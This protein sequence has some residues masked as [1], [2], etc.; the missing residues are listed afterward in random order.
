MS[1]IPENEPTTSAVLP[2]P[3]GPPGVSGF[4]GTPPVQKP[5]TSEATRAVGAVPTENT[6][7]P[8]DESNIG[9]VSVSHISV[10]ESVLEVHDPALDVS[11]GPNISHDA[12]LLLDERLEPYLRSPAGPSG[13]EQPLATGGQ[14][15][16]K[17][18]PSGAFD[19]P[20]EH[21]LEGV[22]ERN[23]KDPFL[24]SGC[25][26]TMDPW[27]F[28]RPETIESGI[29]DG[30]D[31][32]LMKS[33]FVAGMTRARQ[34]AQAIP[35]R[36]GVELTPN[37]LTN[38]M[39]V[40][41]LQADF[42]RDH[43][44]E[45]DVHP[46]GVSVSSQGNHPDPILESM[47]NVTTATAASIQTNYG[48]RDRAHRPTQDLP[49]CIGRTLLLNSNPR[50][51]VEECFPAN[52]NIT[53]MDKRL[54][55]VVAQKMAYRN[56]VA[57]RGG[58]KT[59][60]LADF[61]FMKVYRE[62][63][64][65]G[66][67][68][69]DECYRADS[70]EAELVVRDLIRIG[71]I[72]GGGEMCI[73]GLDSEH[74][75]PILGES[76]ERIYQMAGEIDKLNR[77]KADRPKWSVA[78]QDRW[79]H[80]CLSAGHLANYKKGKLLGGGNPSHTRR[81]GKIYLDTMM[82]NVLA[83]RDQLK[84]C[85]LPLDTKVSQNFVCLIQMFVPGAAAVCLQ[86]NHLEKL[87]PYLLNVLTNP[88]IKK[89]TIDRGSDSKAM[90]HSFN[91]PWNHLNG[92]IDV[93]AA[94]HDIALKP[95]GRLGANDFQRLV[96]RFDYKRPT[97]TGPRDR[98][99]K[100]QNVDY[101]IGPDQKLDADARAYV[102][103]DGALPFRAA[104]FGACVTPDTILN[105]HPGRPKDVALLELPVFN[106]LRK[107]HYLTH[108]EFGRLY[109]KYPA[110]QPENYEL[111]KGLPVI[112][113]LQD[114]VETLI[115]ATPNKADQLEY[116]ELYNHFVR[117]PR[118]VQSNYDSMGLGLVG[119]N[120][121]HECFEHRR[122]STTKTPGVTFGQLFRDKTDPYSNNHV[123]LY[124]REL[125]LYTDFIHNG[126]KE[127]AEYLISCGF[128]ILQAL[129]TH[130]AEKQSR[131]SRNEL[132]VMDYMFFRA[133][134]G[135]ILIRG[136]LWI[137]MEVPENI[138]GGTMRMA[139]RAKL[140][141][142]PE[143]RAHM[144]HRVRR[145]QIERPEVFQVNN[146]WPVDPNQKGRKRVRIGTRMWSE[147][148]EYIDTDF[149][150]YEV[151]VRRLKNPMLEISLQKVRD[152]YER[153]I[154]VRE[155]LLNTIETPEVVVT[156][157]PLPPLPEAPQAMYDFIEAEK[158][159]NRPL[160][161]GQFEAATLQNLQVIRP[162]SAEPEMEMEE[163]IRYMEQT[164]D[165]VM[166]DTNYDDTN[167]PYSCLAEPDAE[168]EAPD[169]LLQ[170]KLIDDH[171]HHPVRYG[172]QLKLYASHAS[173]AG[174]DALQQYFPAAEQFLSVN[175]PLP[176]IREGLIYLNEINVFHLGPRKELSSGEALLRWDPF[177]DERFRVQRE[178]WQI[179]KGTIGL[180]WI[181]FVH[182]LRFRATDKFSS[183]LRPGLKESAAL[184]QSSDAA[185]LNQPID[186]S[187]DELAAFD[188]AFEDADTSIYQVDTGS[189]ETS[190]MDTDVLDP[191]LY[192]QNK[193]MTMA[194]NAA[195]TQF[196]DASIM[197]TT[198]AEVIFARI[199][200]LQV[201][202]DRSEPC[203]LQD[204]EIVDKIDPVANHEYPILDRVIAGFP[205]VSFVGRPQ[206][207]LPVVTYFIQKLGR[208]NMSHYSLAV[209]LPT[210]LQH[211]RQ[212][213][214]HIMGLPEFF[215]HFDSVYARSQKV[216]QH[217]LTSQGKGS[218]IYRAIE[219]RLDQMKEVYGEVT[220][221]IY[222]SLHEQ[223]QRRCVPVDPVIQ[224]E[225]G[226]KD[227]TEILHPQLQRALDRR[228]D[229]EVELRLPPIVRIETEAYLRI[230]HPE[231][232]IFS[233]LQA[234]SAYPM[235]YV[236]S[237][238]N[239]FREN[240][241]WEFNQFYPV[242][243]GTAI[244]PLFSFT[245]LGFPEEKLSVP[246]G[247]A[248][249]RIMVALADIEATAPNVN[250]NQL[251]DFFIR[252]QHR[253]ILEYWR[254]VCGDE[255]KVRIVFRTY[256]HFL[257]ARRRL[258]AP[259]AYNKG[260]TEEGACPFV[261]PTAIDERDRFIASFC[262]ASDH[263][264]V[265]E[266]PLD[267]DRSINRNDGN[268]TIY[269]AMRKSLNGKVSDKMI[270]SSDN[271]NALRTNQA[272]FGKATLVYAYWVQAKLEYQKLTGLNDFETL[273]FI[274][275]LWRPTG[276]LAPS[277]PELLKFIEDLREYT[278]ESVD[279]EMAEQEAPGG[280]ILPAEPR[281]ELESEVSAAELSGQTISS[282][283]SP[284][285]SQRLWKKTTG[286][287]RQFGL[288]ISGK[289]K[290]DQSL[291]PELKPTE[292]R[293]RTRTSPVSPSRDAELCT[294]KATSKNEKRSK[295]PKS[296]RRRGKSA[297]RIPPPPLIP[298]SV[299]EST[300]Q[301]SQQFE[302]KAPFPPG[303]KRRPVVTE[304]AQGL[305]PP[306]SPRRRREALLPSPAPSQTTDEDEDITDHFPDIVDYEPP[307]RHRYERSPLQLDLEFDPLAA[308]DRSGGHPGAWRQRPHA[309]EYPGQ[310][311]LIRSKRTSRIDGS[312]QI[313]SGR[314][315]S[316][317]DSPQ[318][319][320]Q[321]QYQKEPYRPSMQQ[322]KEP[323]RPSMQQPKEP[324]RPKAHYSATTSPALDYDSTSLQY[325]P[326]YHGPSEGRGGNRRGPVP[327]RVPTRSQR[328]PIPA[329]R[330]NSGNR[331][332]TRMFTPSTNRAQT[333]LA[334]PGR[335][336]GWTD[337][338]RDEEHLYVPSGEQ[339]RDSRPAEYGGRGNR[340]PTGNRG[341]GKTS[342]RESIRQQQEDRERHQN[343]ILYGCFQFGKR[344]AYFPDA[345]TND[346]YMAMNPPSRF[347][348]GRRSE[349]AIKNS[350]RKSY[351][352][353]LNATPLSTT[354]YPIHPFRQYQNRSNTEQMGLDHC[355]SFILAEVQRDNPQRIFATTPPDLVMFPGN[356]SPVG[357]QLSQ[358]QA[359]SLG[360]TTAIRP[361]SPGDE[362]RKEAGMSEHYYENLPFEQSMEDITDFESMED[363]LLYDDTGEA[364]IPGSE[365]NSDHHADG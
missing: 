298:P 249:E 291:T 139:R 136:N 191:P 316:Y 299:S 93:Q 159:D 241:P 339:E 44:E 1:P 104:E 248:Q 202:T 244:P 277:I 47:T 271:Y 21:N 76:P 220:R 270:R 178:A 272:H 357:E 156:S 206:K 25:E 173:S 177:E 27:E 351:A 160:A 364:T 326:P 358:L 172:R 254:Y 212:V 16:S 49:G 80:N 90:A 146:V 74:A 125:H 333:A 110:E 297:V 256:L 127:G 145:L 301:E 10:D 12:S 35:R 118:H 165:K 186:S 223:A 126:G 305:N 122:A 40:H 56:I 310:S 314:E 236:D 203:V 37:L 237:F 124:D 176:V 33:F 267:V 30:I 75:Q 273:G 318:E 227:R 128:S 20:V 222:L 353:H 32:S 179:H 324:L 280:H 239:V 155:D 238:I 101:C 336:Q 88:L 356:H 91:I 281:V 3:L 66:N 263:D 26:S 174:T 123:Q 335:P 250:E 268:L 46:R 264:Y 117:V 342:R 113:N 14:T 65:P 152:V 234:M 218:P 92:V 226:Y 86:V 251:A 82:R 303:A 199:A 319:W 42:Y 232:R 39:G 67:L 341:R 175:R 228:A 158:R 83:S 329:P 340:R 315:R 205:L 184:I 24:E 231:R 163:E 94:M 221:I 108:Q 262:N 193:W 345:P 131:V 138:K 352:D 289:T 119:N 196:S 255:D 269:G 34:L 361:A 9:V 73:I 55:Q 259:E 312:A 79:A 61:R 109:H 209:D 140:L 150:E 102:S 29:Q 142:E 58:Y 197:A 132:T 50:F 129:K 292:K 313:R 247:F 57:E 242:H 216:H 306:V 38:T 195:K 51:I 69:T 265:I 187:T 22:L 213:E 45:P 278:N 320:R 327:K 157:E 214:A 120:F 348:W 60:K 84:R 207:P 4:L 287:F 198:N 275:C 68:Y 164:H 311:P 43:S 304:G 161:A 70:M 170:A 137:E 307:H 96:S 332:P 192:L 331:P 31:L 98:K 41:P 11:L 28:I 95:D 334:T 72:I 322:T 105:C 243:L 185:R 274:N 282:T 245:K 302:F 285:A 233:A 103:M 328:P 148:D 54:Q 283:V 317:H 97:D 64:P 168:E 309:P 18:V 288:R 17:K 294:A 338:R 354:V 188:A 7:E 252:C 8:M 99:R 171:D 355:H 344:L 166:I 229:G 141:M 190:Q 204:P 346:D 114:E 208:I 293:P 258:A 144:N 115:A 169:W 211:F 363:L 52:P 180:D 300:S 284:S 321:D 253:V 63:G 296:K 85:N 149:H 78:D 167:D 154:R 13:L 235:P 153:V 59:M 266:C 286:L 337:S 225:K 210:F 81:D 201:T 87:P 217:L 215:A 130:R 350:L 261:A 183:K 53:E 23:S 89:L 19:I 48:T 135:Y 15:T 224:T 134:I 116:S 349:N 246:N 260:T 162:D 200:N 147:W 365:S 308:P 276:R 290:S 143:R 111:Y 71:C 77:L 240:V 112:R 106:A 347:R 279:V 359:V 330:S 2:T 151:E 133:L 295:R 36:P 182:T 360:R 100:M 189:P 121:R 362:S 325:E 230:L 107:W 6:N 194:T 5:V 181:N 323:Y 257:R 219:Q 62:F 343:D